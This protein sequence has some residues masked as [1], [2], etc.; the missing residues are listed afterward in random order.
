MSVPP[1]NA[2]WPPA[3]SLLAQLNAYF[4]SVPPTN[5]RRPLARRLLALLKAFLT[6]KLPLNARR[7]CVLVCRALSTLVL[8]LLLYPSLSRS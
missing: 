2:R 8:T 7:L 1:M 3:R 5:A 4:K 6:N